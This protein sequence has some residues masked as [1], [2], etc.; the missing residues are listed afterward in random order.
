M[1]T[2][3]VLKLHPAAELPRYAHTG[4]FGD[5]AADLY[6]CVGVTLEPAGAIGSTKPV[7]TGIA[8]EFPPTHGALVEDVESGSP[9]DQ[10]GIKAGDV[11]LSVD[12]QDVPHS[13]DLPRMVAPHQPGTQ[14]HV[15]VW[16]DR[17]LTDKSLT[18]VALRDESA[19]NGAETTP[20]GPAESAPASSSLGIAVAEAEGKV[21]VARV[22]SDG[23]ADGKLQ[24]G[25]VIE[26]MDHAAVTSGS[27]LVAKLK[28][29][30]L[31]RPVLLRVRHG[32]QAR[33]VAIVRG[34]A[35]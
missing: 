15:G 28:A 27:D 22:M 7:P 20:Q 24:R 2:I 8:L 19:R 1:P 4:P 13:G 26:E 3:K 11:I 25:D 18:L 14:V 31:D 35:K 30:P 9:A 29:A 32:D 16:H 10:A 12:G 34:T 17:K 21:V 23:P 33:Y 5:L 6:A